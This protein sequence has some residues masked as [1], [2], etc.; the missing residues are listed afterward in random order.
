MSCLLFL[1]L[2]FLPLYLL[3]F[4]SVPSILC[5]PLP[6][7]TFSSACPFPYTSPVIPPFPFF[8]ILT[9]AVLRSGL[10]RETNSQSKELYRRQ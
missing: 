10:G 4:L 1:H 7:F 2:M 5:L 9:L 8:N 3:L 6:S